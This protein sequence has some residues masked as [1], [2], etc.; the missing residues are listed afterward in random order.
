MAQLP[1]PRSSAWVRGG[2]PSQVPL[3]LAVVGA[4]AY[5]AILLLTSGPDPP[6]RLPTPF[7]IPIFDTP[8][9]LVAVGVGYLCLERHRLRQDLES[10]AIG[11]TLWLTALLAFAHILAQPD[12]PVRP[13]NPAIAPYF[14]FACFFAGLAG[15]G[16]AAHYGDRPFPLTDRARVWIGIGVFA[17]GAALAA[18]ILSIQPRLPS[19][20]MPPGR[21]TPLTLRVTGLLLGASALWVVWGGRRRFFGAERD[22]FA[23][24]LLL[25]SVAWMA[26]L[27]GLL[28]SRGF[29]YSVPW[30]LAGLARPL[31]VAIVFFGLLREQAWLY[32]EAHARQRDLESL[33]AAG[34]AL[35][36][37]L[38]P[39]QIA[40]TVAT[41]AVDISGA[42]GAVLFRLDPGDQIVRAVSRAGR[43]SQELV[44]HLE[45]PVGQGASG[46]A[47]AERR[48]VW[49]ANLALPTVPY[50]VSVRTRL[51]REG[52]RAVIAIPLRGQSGEMLGALSVFYRSAH[53]F[54]DADVER[55]SAFGTQASVA[56]ENGRSF[57]QLAL[58][59]RRDEALQAFAQGLLEAI[60]EEEILQSAVRVTRELL[61]A[62]CV[63]VF[64]FD[65]TANCL[66]LAAG[67]GWQAGTVGAMSIAPGTDSF[68]GRAFLHRQTV[69]VENFATEGA[70]GSADFLRYGIQAG[71]DTPLGLR[72][73]AL[74]V[75]AALYRRSRRFTDEESRALMGVAHQTALALEKVRL[76][77]DLQTRLRELTEMQAQLIQADKLK[78]LGTLLSGMAHELNNPLAIIQLSVQQMKAE[79]TLPEPA[80]P[81]IDIIEAAC[82]RAARIVRELLVFARRT[83]P[84]RRRVDINEVIRAALAL[85][86]PELQLNQIRVVTE[87]APL[88]P[89]WADG[90]QLQQVLLNLFGNA[91]DAMKRA[92]GA[93]VLTVR[94]RQ[95]GNGIVIEVEDDGP[96]IAPEHL[97]R[98]F[99]PFFTTKG[100]GEGTG[101][102]LSLSLGLVEAH[103]GHL[104]AE[105]MP[106]AGARF[107]LTL[108]L[109]P[110]MHTAET[111][112]SRPTPLPRCARI[113][114]VEDDAPL[115]EILA[116][117]FADLADQVDQAGTGQAAL[118]CLRQTPYDVI[119][120]DLN[121]PDFDGKVVWRWICEQAPALAPRVIFI[122]GDTLTRATQA[123]LSE[124]GRPVLSK[125]FSIGQITEA[126]NAIVAAA[127]SAPPT[128]APWHP[129]TE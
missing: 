94:S 75:L 78:A 51:V 123:F 98:V 106:G 95:L 41:G 110:E 40:K 113:L 45:L 96:G 1:R 27:M 127:P 20:V 112:E 8:F 3:L 14:F 53:E 64:L 16:L 82:E 50:P 102:G 37:S 52:L 61:A 72:D 124:T 44:D 71:I 47:I 99:D 84:E 46:L 7:A 107:T 15:I 120:L 89:I 79:E 105:N 32:R 57:D 126:V 92:H 129:P 93:G 68:A 2:A 115:R 56:I 26:G 29:R 77:A 128:G 101:L 81:R 58:K 19:P 9:A 33:H 76:Q 116:D 125:P 21:F 49:T 109:G 23:M 42:D 100:V 87:F 59:G 73:Q 17:L 35:V 88:P 10:A 104:R 60:S 66:Q 12:Y 97:H 13:A 108:P 43:F 70:P 31:G 63:G 111:D 103:D 54:D 25:A 91:T 74:G 38:D 5:E 65:P 122:T 30:Y 48:P 28:T 86:A 18:A 62:D 69:R 117:V 114:L 34:Q 39:R 55:L 67:R 121:L 22:A 90:S 118:D 85:Q 119:T 36:R 6:Y 24:Y 83:P 11:T 4:V 80:R